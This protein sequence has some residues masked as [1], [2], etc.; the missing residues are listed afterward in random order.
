MFGGKLVG[1]KKLQK[2]VCETLVKMPHDII[3]F[4]TENC[5]FMGSMDDAWA[6]TFTGN[7]LTNQHLIFL[8]D[9]LFLQKPDQIYYSI[10]HEI[11]HVILGHKNSTFYKQSRKEIQRQEQEADEFAKEYVQLG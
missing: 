7:D 11:G 4:I 3:D 1:N 5:W 8:S 2:Y 6:Y 9:E 10:A